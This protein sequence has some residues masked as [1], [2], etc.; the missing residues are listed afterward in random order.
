[1]ISKNDLNRHNCYICKKKLEVNSGKKM[2]K[3]VYLHFT[4]KD[5]THLSGNPR[6]LYFCPSCWRSAAGEEFMAEG[7]DE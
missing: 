1:M 3:F 2:D 6:F 7:F 5:S 4:D